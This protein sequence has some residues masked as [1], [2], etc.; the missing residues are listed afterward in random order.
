LDRLCRSIFLEMFCLGT[1]VPADPKEVE[2]H[3]I[4]E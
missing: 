2:H 3:L 4:A 1:R